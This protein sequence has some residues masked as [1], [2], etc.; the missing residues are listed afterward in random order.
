MA[1]DVP[2]PGLLGGG[3]APAPL[4]HGQAEALG[5][6]TRAGTAVGS[7]AYCAAWQGCQ[8]RLGFFFSYTLINMT[9]SKQAWAESLLG[10]DLFKGFSSRHKP[11]TRFQAELQCSWTL[12]SSPPGKML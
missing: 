2:V 10:L 11:C 12:P 6:G 3:D 7:R 5:C 4:Q 1:E 9:F 8:V